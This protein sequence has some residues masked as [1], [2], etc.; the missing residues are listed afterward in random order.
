MIC[1][2]LCFKSAPLT[3][4]TQGSGDSTQNFAYFQNALGINA[5]LAPRI[6]HRFVASALAILNQPPA[7]P[8]DKRMKPEQ[9][10]DQ[11]MQHRA[12]IV[13]PAHVAKLM[14]HDR[15]DVR[16][17]RLPRIASGHNRTGLAMP[18]IPGSIDSVVETISTF[19]RR[20]SAV[21]QPRK[22]FGFRTFAQRCRALR[23]RSDAIPANEPHSQHRDRASEPHHQQPR[24]KP[25]Q[26]LQRT[27]ARD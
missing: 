15:F 17:G 22:D 8:P 20:E 3:P 11:H 19:R 6:H 26:H 1:A 27:G 9:R 5:P 2:I 12:Q 7:N 13:A 23:D 14:R 18:K 21:L 16:L 25:R 24:R 4:G 10:F